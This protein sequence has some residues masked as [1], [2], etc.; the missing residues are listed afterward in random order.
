MI[1]FQMGPL[2]LWTLVLSV[3]GLCLLYK[4]LPVLCVLVMALFIVS[5]LDS[6]IEK[7]ENRGFNRTMAITLVFIAGLLVFVVICIL[8]IPP[9]TAELSILNTEIPIMRSHLA[10]HL[11]NIPFTATLSN[12]VRSGKVVVNQSDF[13]TMAETY[14]RRA[15]KI[16]IYAVSGV[17]LASFIM[18]ERN[19]LRGGLFAMV[20]RA[21]HVLLTR[22]LLNLETIVGAYIRGQLLLSSLFTVFT[23]ALLTLVGAEN[24]IVFALFAGMTDVLPYIGVFLSVGP[25][26]F[27]VLPHGET[28]TFIVLIAMLT[29]EE[30]ESRFLVPNV[31]GKQLRLPATIILFALLVGATL[32]GAFAALLSLPIAAAIMMLIEELRVDLPGETVPAE[33]KII[34][35]ENDR[36][37]KEYERRTEGISAQQ[38]AAIAVK[39]AEGRLKNE[40]AAKS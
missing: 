11:S 35:E 40:N 26:V 22:I 6:P 2:T 18:I 9:V 25:A 14:S 39:I 10:D 17:L 3:I 30:F 23:F 8:M 37:E 36:A 29:Y 19:R 5:A 16:L 13:Q 20:P 33:K 28:A 7:I 12:S 27:A 4:L 15:I 34:R 38:S 1:R 31:Y 32:M 21:H 24:A